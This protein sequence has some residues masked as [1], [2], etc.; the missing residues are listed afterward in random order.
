MS[1]T[2]VL[3]NVMLQMLYWVSCSRPS[4]PNKRHAKFLTKGKWILRLSFSVK[5]LL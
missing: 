1:L 3:I 5:S 4:I 2:E